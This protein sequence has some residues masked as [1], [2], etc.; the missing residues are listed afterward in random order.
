MID[1]NKVKQFIENQHKAG[2]LQHSYLTDIINDSDLD[3]RIEAKKLA[4]K[5]GYALLP[6]KGGKYTVLPTKSM[7]LKRFYHG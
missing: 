7:T 3:I 2:N 5:L 1:F 6:A 4:R